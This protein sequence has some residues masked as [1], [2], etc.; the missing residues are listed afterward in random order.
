MTEETLHKIF[1]GLLKEYHEKEDKLKEDLIAEKITCEEFI[2]K[3]CKAT[4]KLEELTEKAKANFILST[5][6]TKAL[7]LTIK[8]VKELNLNDKH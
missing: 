5:A 4:E 8:K 6:I 1:Q 2:E 7:D 3:Q